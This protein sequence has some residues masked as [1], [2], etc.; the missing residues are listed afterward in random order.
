[1]EG[2]PG[3]PG[4][5]PRRLEATSLTPSTWLEN[6]ITSPGGLETLLPACL[7]LLPTLGM[8]S[9]NGS[10]SRLSSLRQQLG[11]GG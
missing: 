6:V 5:R 1:M 3:N 9:R 2:R 10:L 11:A 7:R 8:G 4:L